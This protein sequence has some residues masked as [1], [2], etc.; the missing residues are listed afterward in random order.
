M[1]Y[2]ITLWLLLAS[3]S[4]FAE[5][6]NMF[7]KAAKKWKNHV[8]GVIGCV[9][10]QNTLR[11]A[12][13]QQELPYRLA[14]IIEAEF[15]KPP[16]ERTMPAELQ[17]SLL[18]LVGEVYSITKFNLAEKGWF[19]GRQILTNKLNGNDPGQ[20]V[21]LAVT[22][23]PAGIIH[24]ATFGDN[25]Y[26]YLIKEEHINGVYKP[27]MEWLKSNPEPCKEEEFCSIFTEIVLFLNQQNLLQKT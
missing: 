27:L 12:E 21:V 7:K 6:E 3:F 20:V 23:L 9:E 14:K 16:E 26:A 25:V 8:V 4:V 11:R 24:C 17:S 22:R 1:K 18:K 5:N 2:F 19:S 10:F 15:A 13:A